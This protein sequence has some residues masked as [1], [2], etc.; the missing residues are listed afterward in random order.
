MENL[1]EE[2]WKEK[3]KRARKYAHFDNK[4]GLSEEVYK[5]IKNKNNIIKHGFYPFIYFENKLDKVYK[6][7]KN[8]T[9]SKEKIRK[10]CYSAH[11][12]RY[13]YS[14]YSFKLNLKYNKYVKEHGINDVAVAY[15]TNLN[16]NNIE[17]ANKVFKFIKNQKNCYILVGD[18]TNF[19]DKLDH[20]YLKKN[21]SKLFNENKIP[22]DYYAVFKNITKYSKWD[23][24]E[25]LKFKNKEVN[26][27]N[28]KEL[29]SQ[30]KILT[31]KEF[32][33]NKKQQVKKNL[34]TFGIPQGSAISAVL[35]NIYMMEFD[36]IIKKYTE[37]FSGL[38]LRYCDDFTVVI[39]K[40]GEDDFRNI[41]NEIINLLTKD[42]KVEI[43]DEKTKIFKYEKGKIINCNSKF[44]KNVKDRNNFFNYLGFTFDGKEIT[45]R[46]KTISK[47]YYRM[48]RKLKTIIKKDGYVKGKRISCKNLYEK[49]SVKGAYLKNK[50]GKVQGNFITYVDRAYK[51]FGDKA[52]KR[53][54]KRHML[55][56]RRGL[57]KIN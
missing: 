20:K 24:K 41:Y 7:D 21:L 42:Q 46:D 19:F 36:E 32:K 4:V 13:I 51:I 27:K 47:Y 28:I 34:L 50:E 54:T 25:I 8:K 15:R 18:F 5:Y 23:L 48:Y 11:I 53:K 44:L 30:S 33:E 49:Y 55:K 38:Y 26:F 2:K 45:I 22:D 52:I 16:K 37:T 9:C 6:D 29:N 57:D 1:A 56:I 40:I 3:N 31:K 17:F 35:S 14:Y 43:Q 39:P 12:D 10:L